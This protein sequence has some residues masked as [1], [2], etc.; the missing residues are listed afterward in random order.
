MHA[1]RA[2]RCSRAWLEYGRGGDHR[3]GWVRAPHRRALRRHRPRRPAPHGRDRASRCRRE[4]ERSSVARWACTDQGR[5]RGTRYAIACADAPRPSSSSP[6]ALPTTFLELARASQV[7]R[8]G[9]G[10][11]N[12]RS[13]ADDDAVAR[14]AT[15]IDVL[16]RI[17]RLMAHE[18]TRTTS[19][20]HG[21]LTAGLDAETSHHT[22]MVRRTDDRGLG[23]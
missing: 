5:A 1:M 20:L 14:P 13:L 12:L 17:F 4:R 6:A 9:R 21:H 2:R 16:A 15:K 19:A 3:L 23:A 7:R 8:G 18:S 10:Q 11:P 22:L